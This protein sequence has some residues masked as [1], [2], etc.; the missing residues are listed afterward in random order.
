M[1]VERQLLSAQRQGRMT[2]PLVS[3]HYT[4]CATA[5]V[6]R[7]TACTPQRVL[8]RWATQHLNWHLHTVVDGSSKASSSPRGIP[9]AAYD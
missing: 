3:K 8:E 4:H 1:Q 6:K 5:S 7:I 2:L 9:D